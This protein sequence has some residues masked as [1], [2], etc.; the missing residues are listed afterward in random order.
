MRG[1]K[2]KD[3]KKYQR[4]CLK[5]D[6][7]EY[8]LYQMSRVC[9]T[10]T[11]EL[12]VVTIG[13][14]TID[15][16][17]ITRTIGSHIDSH[18]KGEF[19]FR[20]GDKIPVEEY[21]IHFGGNSSNVSVALSKLSLK[22]GIVTEIGDDDFSQKILANLKNAGVDTSFVLKGKGKSSF[23]VII[24]FQGERTIFSHHSPREHKFSLENLDTKWI[25]LTSL[26][27]EWREPYK[28]VLSWA[29]EKNAKI[30]FNPGQPQIDSGLS[31]IKEIIENSYILFLNKEESEKILNIKDESIE[32][33]LVELRKL[34]PKIAVITDGNKGSYAMDENG[35][36]YF[37][38]P[39]KTQITERTGA[40][41][42]YSSGFLGAMVLGKSIEEAM[43]WGTKNA[44][45]VIQKVGAQ[46]GLLSRQ[47][48]ESNF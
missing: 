7:H 14:T 22:S 32:H 23:S 43:R 37:S 31:E 4:T 15:A 25:Y 16:F 9:Y 29:L 11:V 44:G 1:K 12:D 46:E 30:V 38:E 20:H 45:S 3:S 36:T 17:L 8:L 40:G 41:D 2:N 21:K 28:R 39:A 5:E 13:E 6:F 27:E 33:L 24:S 48:L 35:K 19:C 42:S 47:E 18:E 10:K 34:G 26:G